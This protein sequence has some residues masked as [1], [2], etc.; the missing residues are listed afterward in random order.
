MPK[1]E[2]LDASF[3]NLTRLEK[4]FHGLPVLCLADLSNNRI[5]SISPELV[6]KTRCSNHGVLNKLEILLQGLHHILNFSFQHCGN[7]SQ[8][9]F[10]ISE[11]P[12]LCQD[13]L[14]VLIAMMEA[15]EARLL[16]IAHCIMRQP[17]IAQN[18]QIFLTPPIPLLPMLKAQIPI[19]PNNIMHP[20]PSIVQVI[21]PAPIILQPAPIE[22]TTATVPT[23]P[24]TTTTTSSTVSSTTTSTIST[25]I[26]TEAP[27]TTTISPT[28]TIEYTST[29]SSSTTEMET[30]PTLDA[31]SF[32]EVTPI[33][34][35]TVPL[36]TI[37][38]DNSVD[39]NFSPM[40]QVIGPSPDRAQQLL[41]PEEPPEIV[42]DESLPTK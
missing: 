36:T 39:E 11:N 4:D 29:Q 40:S 30:L 26:T 24:S 16:G 32:I 3:N 1:L 5:T 13:E 28:S 37:E 19:I 27:L 38:T 42:H 12:I 8:L 15:Q 21:I 34:V 14:P 23:T 41:E 25:T 9:L 18:S 10:T 31:R 17:E 35:T 6:A 2:K 7:Q 22:Q 20:S 33:P